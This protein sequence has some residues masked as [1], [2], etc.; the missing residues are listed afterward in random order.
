MV[1]HQHGTGEH[2]DAA[3]D[4]AEE[5][6]HQVRGGAAGRDIVDPGIVMPAGGAEVGDERDDGDPCIDEPLGGG[7]DIRRIDGNEGNTVRFLRQ[8]ILQRRDQSAS[9]EGRNLDDIDPGALDGRP[10]EGRLDLPP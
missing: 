6:P 8:H 4:L 2:S 5:A 3:I 10:F 9:I 1:A 7:T